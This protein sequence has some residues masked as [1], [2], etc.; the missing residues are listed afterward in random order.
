VGVKQPGRE[1]GHSSSFSAY[2]KNMWN[3]TS[4]PRITFHGAKGENLPFKPRKKIC[5]ISISFKVLIAL[6][7]FQFE[8]HS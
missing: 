6:N 5:R 4:T 7:A 2:V 3:Y 8:P 1:V